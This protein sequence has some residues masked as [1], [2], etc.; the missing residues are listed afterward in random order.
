VDVAAGAGAVVYEVVAAGAGSVV[1]EVVA[2][3]AGV[4][5][6]EKPVVESL[7]DDAVTVKVAVST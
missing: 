3:G 2:A 5:V 1:Y 7:F 6:V 4:A